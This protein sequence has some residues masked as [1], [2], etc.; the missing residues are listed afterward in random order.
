MGLA[1]G[2]L[3][4]VGSPEGVAIGRPDPMA[5]YLQSGDVVSAEVLQIG[6]LETYIA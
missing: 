5:F 4:T 3:I 2:D 6:A 1:R